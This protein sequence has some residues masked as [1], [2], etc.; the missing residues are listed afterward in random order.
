ME[1]YVSFQERLLVGS[2]ESLVGL[3]G[4]VRADVHLAGA[5]RPGIGLVGHVALPVGYDK[6]TGDYV[7]RPEFQDRVLETSQ[8]LM[9][10]DV[11]VR[12]IEVQR[13][14]NVE[15]G[16]TVYIGGLTDG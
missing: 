8:K 13:V 12:A 1:R 9:S 11:V 7:I 14:S 6:Y 3:T 5:I 2:A 10:D 16:L 15:G 4:S